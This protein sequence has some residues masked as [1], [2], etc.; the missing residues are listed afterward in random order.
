MN[1]TVTIIVSGKV[2]GVFFRA[3]T[4]KTALRLALNGYTRNLPDGRVEI[5][6]QGTEAAIQQLIDW[7]QKGPMLAKVEKI[8][9]KYYEN[10]SFFNDFDIR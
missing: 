6:A 1:K 4:K 8:E 9:V 7:S 5:V 3:S 10:E 2:Q